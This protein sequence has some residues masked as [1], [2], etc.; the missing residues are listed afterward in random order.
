MPT[1]F[2]N[3]RIIDPGSGINACL[4]GFKGTFLLS[5]FYSLQDNGWIGHADRYMYEE[6]LPATDKKLPGRFNF[7][8]D[9]KEHQGSYNK[10]AVSE[11]FIPTNN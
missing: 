6:W 1:V 4:N 9:G 10:N 5:L 11:I 2:N 7:E 8:H 3:G